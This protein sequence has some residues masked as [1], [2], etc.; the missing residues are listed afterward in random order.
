MRWSGGNPRLINSICDSALLMAFGD[1]SA[2]VG[3]DYIRNAA[4]NLALIPP[5]T[6]ELVEAP[7]R[8]NAATALSLTDHGIPSLAPYG[9]RQ[10]PSILKRLAGK[11]GFPR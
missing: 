7:F 4:L 3:L 1:T 2:S 6:P 9:S 11:L 5:P 10:N 8:Q